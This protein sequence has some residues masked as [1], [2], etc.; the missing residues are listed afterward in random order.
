MGSVIQFPVVGAKFEVGD[1]VRVTASIGP[2]CRTGVV[3]DVQRS[4]DIIVYTV[5]HDEP[6]FTEGVFAGKCDFD[7]GETELEPA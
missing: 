3:A 7:W 6:G 2:N 5:I 4:D 1:H